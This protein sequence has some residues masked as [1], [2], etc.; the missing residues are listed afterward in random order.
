VEVVAGLFIGVGGTPEVLFVLGHLLGVGAVT[1]GGLR[2]ACL[3][4]AIEVVPVPRL[5]LTLAAS[6]AALPA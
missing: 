3:G 1:N 4:Q 2:D 6:P 5:A